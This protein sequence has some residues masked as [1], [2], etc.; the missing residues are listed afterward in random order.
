MNVELLH[1]YYTESAPQS[2]DNGKIEAVS[3]R[4]RAR[5]LEHALFRAAAWAFESASFSRTF[6]SASSKR[7]REPT[8]KEHRSKRRM[9]RL[10]PLVEPG[11]AALAFEKAAGVLLG[12]EP[13]DAGGRI[14]RKKMRVELFDRKER[15]HE[16]AVGQ[17][18]AVGEGGEEAAPV[19]V[20]GDWLGI[21][22]VHVGVVDVFG[23]EGEHGGEAMRGAYIPVKL[24][25]G[26]DT[27]LDADIVGI[28]EGGGADGIVADIER[29]KQIEFAL[30]SGPERARCGVRLSMPWVL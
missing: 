4:D 26:V 14:G 20:V 5:V 25:L 8:V 28:R 7:S 12:E 11:V 21:E 1:F 6:C 18:P 13:H 19:E 9:Q 16:A 10:G 27:L 2:P 3:Q 17:D 22:G 24:R 15:L 30:M 23:I 29:L